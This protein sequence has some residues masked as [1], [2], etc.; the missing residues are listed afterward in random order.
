ME[1]NAK[2][3]FCGIFGCSFSVCLRLVVANPSI[4]ARM[5]TVIAWHLPYWKSHTHTKK[6]CPKYWKNPKEYFTTAAHWSQLVDI[7]QQI[8]SRPTHTKAGVLVS[9][10]LFC[11]RTTF[12]WVHQGPW[13]LA[14][15]GFDSMYLRILCSNSSKRKKSELLLVDLGGLK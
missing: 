7:V 10:I 2:A 11:I 8:Q 9:I 13:T 14:K 6:I 3:C 15:L 5:A 4:Y 1:S 12:I